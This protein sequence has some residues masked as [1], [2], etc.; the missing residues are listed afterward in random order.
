MVSDE[1]TLSDTNVMADV[2]M[3]AAPFDTSDLAFDIHS[4]SWITTASTNIT[5]RNVRLLTLLYL[6]YVRDSCARQKHVYTV[7][8]RRKANPVTV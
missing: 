6:V 1:A 8:N 2:I 7:N 3:S 5:Q 4:G